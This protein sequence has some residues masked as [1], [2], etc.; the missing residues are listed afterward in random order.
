MIIPPSLWVLGSLS[1]VLLSVCVFHHHHPTAD[2]ALSTLM[3][4]VCACIITPPSPK[5]SAMGSFLFLSTLD[6]ICVIFPPAYLVCSPPPLMQFTLPCTPSS[7]FL[8]V[9]LS[10]CSHYCHLLVVLLDLTRRI[11]QHA[12]ALPERTGIH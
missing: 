7:P 4:C 12:A 11:A 10:L 6:T 8:L 2:S 5:D 9:S 3:V 1:T